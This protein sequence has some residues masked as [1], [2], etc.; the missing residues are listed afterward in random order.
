MVKE[1]ENVMVMVREL[2][3]E[4]QRDIALWVSRYVVILEEAEVM[5]WEERWIAHRRRIEDIWKRTR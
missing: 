3:E 4:A 5:T 2:P 1:L